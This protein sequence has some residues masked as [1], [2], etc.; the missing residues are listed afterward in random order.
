MTP[1][2][3]A[4]YCVGHQTLAPAA[5]TA[6]TIPVGTSRIRITSTGQACRWRNDGTNP[7][8]AVGMY[9]P[10]NTMLELEIADLARFRI[11]EVAATAA[12]DV[13]YWSPTRLA[14]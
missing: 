9:L 5:A 13:S 6:L 11:I 14:S 2:N 10:V 1:G 12:V 3:L 7:T 8:A 4:E